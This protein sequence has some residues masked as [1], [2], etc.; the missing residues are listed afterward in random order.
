MSKCRLYLII[1]FILL[2]VKG[3]S[4]MQEGLYDGMSCSIETPFFEFQS[5]TESFV[6][7]LSEIEEFKNPDQ[8]RQPALIMIECKGQLYEDA[9][10]N[11]VVPITIWGIIDTHHEPVLTA[12]RISNRNIGYIKIIK[13][14]KKSIIEIVL[15]DNQENERAEH[16]VYEKTR[17]LKI[18]K[19]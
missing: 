16:I 3:F 15:I 8:S 11:S 10:L 6:I 9:N 17:K 14:S 4:Q 18:E 19:N 7:I 12:T 13:K 5:D 1:I 2:S